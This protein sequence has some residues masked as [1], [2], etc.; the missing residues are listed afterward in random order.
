MAILK[1]YT[2]FGL[3][4]CEICKECNAEYLDNEI[5]EKIKCSE[6]FMQN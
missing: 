6:S 2:D 3:K 1:K 4:K 5:M